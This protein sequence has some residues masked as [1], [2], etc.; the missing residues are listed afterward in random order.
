[1]RAS[2]CSIIFCIICCVF[3]SIAGIWPFFIAAIISSRLIGFPFA[4]VAGPPIAMPLPQ[5]IGS[6]GW[7]SRPPAAAMFG[8]SD[9]AISN[10]SKPLWLRIFVR[11]LFMMSPCR[12]IASS[13]SSVCMNVCEPWSMKY[14]SFSE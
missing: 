9:C 12:S 2:C 13:S 1:M 8:Q 11:R 3:G 5:S 4:P 14:A 6:S 10:G 7:R